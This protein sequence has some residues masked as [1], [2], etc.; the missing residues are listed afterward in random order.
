MDYHDILLMMYRE[1][2][3]KIIQDIIK[4]EES[5]G[6]LHTYNTMLVSLYR[7]FLGESLP[8]F[9]LSVKDDEEKRDF[10]NNIKDLP[11][12]LKDVL[13]NRLDAAAY[14][15]GTYTR[16]STKELSFIVVNFPAGEFSH[17]C[18]LTY[19][20]GEMCLELEREYIAIFQKSFKNISKKIDE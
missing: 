7:L 13:I 4:T 8:T 5:E 16:Q 10:D 19:E 2:D 1:L 14:Y 18:K 17:L 12:A 15:K 11:D 6:I 3:F 9:Q 20:R